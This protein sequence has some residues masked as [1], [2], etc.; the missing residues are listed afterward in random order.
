MALKT[1]SCAGNKIRGRDV[2]GHLQAHQAELNRE[3]LEIL[4]SSPKILIDASEGRVSWVPCG[5][6][7]KTW[8]PRLRKT[9]LTGLARRSI[10]DRWDCQKGISAFA[11]V[12]VPSAFAMKRST[13]LY[14]T[15]CPPFCPPFCVLLQ[16][17]T[18]ASQVQ[19]QV[20]SRLPLKFLCA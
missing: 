15:F 10:G 2:G 3:M 6:N 4:R 16:H 18:P 14:L 7:S 12:D 8:F 5:T 11:S 9:G 13:I 17:S 20:R 19:V 1:C